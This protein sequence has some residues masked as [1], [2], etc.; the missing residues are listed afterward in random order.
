MV[1]VVKLTLEIYPTHQ[2]WTCSQIYFLTLFLFF[3]T[4]WELTVEVIIW[5]FTRRYVTH[6]SCKHKAILLYNFN[7]VTTL[8]KFIISI[9]TKY[10][11]SHVYIKEVFLIPD[12]LMGYALPFFSCFFGF[13]STDFFVG[14]PGYLHGLTF[15]KSP[16]Q[17]L[18]R[19]SSSGYIWWFYYDLIWV[20]FF[21][22]QSP[23]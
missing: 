18:C 11:F 13:L 14:K 8:R 22:W 9:H 5:N 23:T 4:I 20:R 7:R 1:R 21:F 19:M 10:R 2:L 12:A 15:V 16:G 17:F 3:W 6:V